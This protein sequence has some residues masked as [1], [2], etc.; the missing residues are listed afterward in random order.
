MRLRTFSLHR[1]LLLLGLGVVGTS[2]Y[3]AAAHVVVAQAADGA[4]VD[5]V[6][7]VETST[8]V[9]VPGARVYAD[10]RPS[11]FLRQRLDAAQLLHDEGIVEHILV[12]GDNRKSHYNEPEAMQQY[13][14]DDGVAPSDVTMDFAGFDTWDTCIRANEQFGV[15]KAVVVT[16]ERFANRTAALCLAAGIDTQ[17]LALPTPV[18]GP[19]PRLR[20]MIRE[21]LA[22][23]KAWGDIV[24]EPDAHHGGDYVGL[25]GSETP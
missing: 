14:V 11:Q 3:V 6:S 22:N 20:S 8:A 10:G 17:I 24:R 19:K 23:V 5:S 1:F 2:A 18:E 25:V 12:S 7:D 4:V 15:T 16:Q 9:I 13:I 21:R